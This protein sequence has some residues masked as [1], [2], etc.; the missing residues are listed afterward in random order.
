MRK[1]YFFHGKL[2]FTFILQFNIIQIGR[3][4]RKFQ[5]MD[6]KDLAKDMEKKKATEVQK[7]YFHKQ[8]WLFYLFLLIGVFEIFATAL[9]G[10]DLLG[11]KYIETQLM[12]YLQAQYTQERIEDAKAVLEIAAINDDVSAHHTKEA[13]TYLKQVIQTNPDMW[14][15][16]LIADENGVEIAHTEGERYYGISFSNERVF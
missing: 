2:Q 12:V 3:K 6:E 5:K 16:F 8:K 1:T 10:K 15:H 4:T 7:K 11:S 9:L 13:E 14:S